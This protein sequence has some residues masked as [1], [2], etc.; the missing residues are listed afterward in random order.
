MG[1]EWMGGIGWQNQVGGTTSPCSAS[2]AVT[3]V[4]NFCA[5]DKATTFK[6]HFVIMTT[7]LH[8]KHIIL[9]SVWD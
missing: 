6:V 2:T 5:Q 4:P 8:P 9:H 1:T 3:L 7:E